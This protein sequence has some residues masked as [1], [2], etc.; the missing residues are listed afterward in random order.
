MVCSDV[1]VNKKGWWTCGSV[2]RWRPPREVLEA[3]E[4]GRPP[5]SEDDIAVIAHDFIEDVIDDEPL[6]CEFKYGLLIDVLECEGEAMD[7]VLAID[8]YGGSVVQAW[9]R[10][11]EG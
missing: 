5:L 9:W 2:S 10:P 6:R 3:V 1:R 11:K 7:I 4:G 8:K